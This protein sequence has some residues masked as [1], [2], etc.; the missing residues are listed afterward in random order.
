M[1]QITGF[2]TVCRQAA[3]LPGDYV[4]AGRE[5]GG[6]DTG[7]ELFKEVCVFFSSVC[8]SLILAQ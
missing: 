7:Y 6:P 1:P 2:S 8:F 5:P 4:A 3:R